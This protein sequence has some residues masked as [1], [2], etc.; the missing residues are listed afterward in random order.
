MKSKQTT[1]PH[2]LVTAQDTHQF[3]LAGNAVFTL[4]SKRT[5]TRYTYKVVQA[6]DPSN[7]SLPDKWYVR[8]LTG[9]DWYEYLGTLKG[10]PPTFRLAATSRITADAPSVKAFYW[11]WTQVLRE[12][13]HPEL[14]VWH[15]GRCGRCGRRLTVPSSIANGIGPECQ[16]AIMQGNLLMQVEGL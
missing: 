2:Q 9:P 5:G 4:R 16:Q 8:V 13:M 3:V 7:D 6:K 10:S 1:D 14:E 15:E 12:R 11:F